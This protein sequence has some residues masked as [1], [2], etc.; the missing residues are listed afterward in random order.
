MTRQDMTNPPAMFEKLVVNVYHLPARIPENG[1]HS[2]FNQR[3]NQNSSS[4]IPHTPTLPVSWAVVKRRVASR[5]I[6]RRYSASPQKILNKKGKVSHGQ[7]GKNY[8]P[9]TAPSG[10]TD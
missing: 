2:L 7:H 4:R 5:R 3:L 6:H 9:L 8:C 10:V 1:I